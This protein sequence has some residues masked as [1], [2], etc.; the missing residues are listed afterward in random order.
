ML[1]VTFQ[2][3]YTVAPTFTVCSC[4]CVVVVK[5]LVHL[6][7]SKS[8]LFCQDAPAPRPPAVSGTVH[9]GHSLSAG[10]GVLPPGGTQFHSSLTH[11]MMLSVFKSQHINFLL[12]LRVI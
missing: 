4:Y 1:C 3:I 9:R 12:P 6:N 8:H 11:T 10:H 7:L 5:V 2:H